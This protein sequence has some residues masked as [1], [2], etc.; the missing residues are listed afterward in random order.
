[1]RLTSPFPCCLALA[2]LATPV[3]ASPEPGDDGGSAASV[4]PATAEL[5]LDDITIEGEIDVPQV[6]FITARESRRGGDF[7]HRFYLIDVV[8]LGRETPAGGLL[9]PDPT[10]TPVPPTGSHDEE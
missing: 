3:F 5:R 7:L 6:L 8:R 10:P 1:M 4:V 2:L 9:L